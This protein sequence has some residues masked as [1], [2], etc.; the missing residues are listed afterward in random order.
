MSH[1]N[2]CLIHWGNDWHPLCRLCLALAW[3]GH[4]DGDRCYGRVDRRRDRR[5]YDGATVPADGEREFFNSMISNMDPT[6]PAPFPEHADELTQASIPYYMQQPYSGDEETFFGGH[7][8]HPSSDLTR[9]QTS[10]HGR[11]WA[12]ISVTEHLEVEGPPTRGVLRTWR[13]AAD[14]AHPARVP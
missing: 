11:G 13:P 1:E 4:G 12:K 10:F 9:P 8:S 5:E 7:I 6:L 14:S 2:P 3:A